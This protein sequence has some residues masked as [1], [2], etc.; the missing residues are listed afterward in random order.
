MLSNLALGKAGE[1]R[2]ASELLLRGHDV[3]LT[4]V[5]S[6]ADLIL[7]NG[8]RIQVKAANR[9]KFKAEKKYLCSRYSFSFKSWKRTT[10]HYE[11]HKLESV[12]YIILW[13]VNDDAF[14]IIPANEVRG[15]Y[16]VRLTLGPKDH[17]KYLA[18]RDN[19]DALKS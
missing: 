9:T 6:G 15:K 10:N 16:S 4:I 18:F 2:V 14:F 11:S 13:T 8:K 17:S 1:L 19:W 12:D 5:D 3:F 7:G